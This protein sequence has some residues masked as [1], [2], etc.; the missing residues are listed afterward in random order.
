MIQAR[1][2]AINIP[3]SPPQ[4]VRHGT[5]AS[6]L[7]EQTGTDAVFSFCTRRVSSFSWRPNEDIWTILPPTQERSHTDG[8]LSTS[9]CKSTFVAPSRLLKTAPVTST[10][11]CRTS[12]RWGPCRARGGRFDRS[13]LKR[14]I[15]GCG[16]E[17]SGGSV[18]VPGRCRR[19][20]SSRFAGSELGGGPSH[21]V[22]SWGGRPRCTLGIPA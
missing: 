18:G 19:V 15:W 4:L 21:V 6:V 9:Q 7:V 13:V 20:V 11:V 3:L 14:D 12:V 17:P 8:E 10:A 22:L 2:K 1:G 16:N 5:F